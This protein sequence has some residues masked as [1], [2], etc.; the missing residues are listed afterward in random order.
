MICARPKLPSSRPVSASGLPAFILTTLLALFPA[1]EARAQT[2]QASAGSNVS[3]NGPDPRHSYDIVMNFGT[4]L[5]SRNGLTESVPG[6]GMRAAAPT[7]KGI[8]EAGFYSGIGNGTIYRSATIDY[9]MDLIADLVVAHFLLGFHG[10]QFS[11]ETA[12]SRYAGGWHYG[13]GV[14]QY[15]AGPF[16]FRFD[17][18]HRFSPGQC[19]EITVGLTYRF[20]NANGS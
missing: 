1:F 13:G 14:T 15:L 5:P 11:S 8:F 17:F 6:W 7:S 4:L 3:E 9:R 18:R 2:E 12:S 16:L 20:G 19:V 10:D